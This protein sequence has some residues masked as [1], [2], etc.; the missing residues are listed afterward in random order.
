[1]IRPQDF[2]DSIAHETKVCQ[3]LATKVDPKQL[4]Y[5][6]GEKTRS[7]IELMRYL[8]WCGVV[9]TEALIGGDW[10]VAGRYREDA[11]E[12]PLEDFSAR[13]DSQLSRVRELIEGVPEAEFLTR[14]APLP[15]GTSTILGK[16]L[17]DTALKFV[18]AYRLQLFQNIKCCGAKDLSSSEAW[19]G[20]DT[21]PV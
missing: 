18:S 2:I 8:T 16:G 17:V 15:W 5:R 3:F 14:E 12:M 11:S 19:M 21:Q 9:P 1:M 13:M 6:P 4:G 20:M 7:T 10:S